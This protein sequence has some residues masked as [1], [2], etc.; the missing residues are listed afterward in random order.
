MGAD[1]YIKSINEKCVAKAEPKFRDAVAKRDKAIYNLQRAQKLLYCQATIDKLQKAK[2]KA[3]E[4]VEK[5]FEAMYETGYFR[6]S[7][8]SSSILWRLGLSWW[9]MA[10]VNIDSTVKNREPYNKVWINRQDF[11][12]ITAVRN[13]LKIV[14]ETEL[15]PV[16]AE[17]IR[18]K[19]IEDTPKEW[20]DY[21]TEKKARFEAF[22]QQAIDLKEAIRCSV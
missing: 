6:D 11:M 18:E 17:W 13:L 5:W 16:D 1:L 9:E 8:N 20:N 19:G 3:Q 21:F 14:K 2:D 7:Y 10:D 15:E 12:P 4:T 22:L